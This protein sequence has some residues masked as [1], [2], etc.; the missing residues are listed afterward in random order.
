MNI[1]KEKCHLY[2]ILNTISMYNNYFASPTP[3]CL[4]ETNL[5]GEEFFG[6]WF[7]NFIFSDGNDDVQDKLSAF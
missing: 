6:P 5:I 2:F 4:V 3:Q 1:L 7:L